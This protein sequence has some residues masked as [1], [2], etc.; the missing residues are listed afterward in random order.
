ML[1][2]KILKRLKQRFNQKGFSLVELMVV[3]A[4]IGIL[5]SIAIPNF[6]RFQR[7]SRQSGSKLLL[8]GI[9][10]AQRTFNTEWGYGSSCLTQTGYAQEGE[11]DYY[12]GWESQ[13]A[14]NAD[15]N[16][17]DI[18]TIAERSDVVGGANYRGPLAPTTCATKTNGITDIGSNNLST[19]SFFPG[20]PKCTC[21]S[22]QGTAKATTKANCADTT[23][24]S[25]CINSGTPVAGTWAAGTAGLLEPGLTGNTRNN[26]T[27]TAGA[28]GNIGGTALDS[29][30]ITEQKVIL[31]TSDGL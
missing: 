23:G 22:G 24:Q 30:I 16:V 5:A 6:Q 31:N 15:A 20:I 11:S 12:A 7:K 18:D 3:V 1:K 17:G 13:T 2:Q 29:W 19:T 25:G 26:I 14:G 8:S 9:F 28:L 10:T 21:A 27:F 4:I